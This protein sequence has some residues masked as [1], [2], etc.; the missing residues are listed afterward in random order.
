M[1]TQPSAG[2]GSGDRMLVCAWCGAVMRE[3]ALPLSHG[4][5]AAC[6]ELDLPAGPL[7]LV[8]PEELDRLPFGVVRLSGDGVIQAYNRS[9]SRHARRPAASVIGRNFFTEVAPCTDVQGFHGRLEHMRAQGEHA[10]E[11]FSFAFRL[12]WTTVTVALALSYD[13]VTD[14]ATVIVDWP[15]E[16]GAEA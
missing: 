11:R 7:T 15:P 12:P 5:C 10:C 3:G 4:I 6:T 14:S 8:P 2:V 16:A 13:P 1:K 9:E